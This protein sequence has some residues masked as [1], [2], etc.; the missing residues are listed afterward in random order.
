MDNNLTG[1]INLLTKKPKKVNK[2]NKYNKYRKYKKVI[3]EKIPVDNKVR[4]NYKKIINSKTEKISEKEPE[5]K[6]NIKNKT[7][8]EPEKTVNVKNKNE[9]TV[10]VKTEKTVN[11][12]NK[13]E[14]TVNVKNKNEKTV[15]KKLEVKNNNNL[16]GW[17]KHDVPGDGNCA[18]HSIMKYFEKHNEKKK[19][20]KRYGN[21]GHS[22]RNGI[23]ENVKIHID[24]YNTL[25]NTNNSKKYLNSIYKH[26]LVN[27]SKS[28]I[29]KH[30]N[31][32]LKLIQQKSAQITIDELQ[33][34]SAML[35]KKIFVYSEIEKKWT[36]ISI[37]H[38]DCKSIAI[39]DAI[40]L[41]F[42]NNHY[43]LLL[44]DNNYI[45]KN[46]YNDLPKDILFNYTF[47][48]KK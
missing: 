37:P 30:M 35:C 27:N 2:S 6:V 39:Q 45:F 18:F 3:E 32:S 46:S 23:S 11:V 13:N 24:L 26:H 34:I 40:F 1:L 17:V 7:E 12:K 28:N 19:L 43:Q 8:K 25:T 22:L 9:K 47:L 15:N 10:N 48:Q 42:N 14:K 41:Y 31:T 5:K 44:P 20:D 29:K 36:N 16:E 21:T 33:I 4:K 38:D